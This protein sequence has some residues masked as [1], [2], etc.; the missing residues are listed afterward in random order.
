VSK[1]LGPLSN[2]A[3]RIFQD[4]NKKPNNQA[5]VRSKQDLPL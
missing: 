2:Q 1:V 3:K 5:R 4:E